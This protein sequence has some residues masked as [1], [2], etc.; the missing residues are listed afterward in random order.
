MGSICEDSVIIQSRKKAHEFDLT[1]VLLILNV[2]LAAL[3]TI[4]TRQALWEG[5]H[6][7]VS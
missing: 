2:G 6:L 7:G 1:D 5:Q 4:C 3:D